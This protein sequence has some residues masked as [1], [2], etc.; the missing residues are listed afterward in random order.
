LNAAAGIA[1]ADMADCIR[2]AMPIA[3]KAIDS[4]AAAAALEKLIKMS[5]A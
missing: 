5:N 4:G 3:E 1:V 2:S